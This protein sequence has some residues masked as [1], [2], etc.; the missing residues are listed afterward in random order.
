M[1]KNREKNPGYIYI[2]TVYSIH[3]QVN[4]YIYTVYIYKYIYIYA[5]DLVDLTHLI[6]V[7][8]RTN[9]RDK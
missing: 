3:I 5:V 6:V 2:Y 8:S 4:I 9:R 7:M 1:Y